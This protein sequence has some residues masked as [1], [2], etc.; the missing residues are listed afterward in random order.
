MYNYCRPL[1]NKQ[2]WSKPDGRIQEERAFSPR[3]TGV[4][5]E[6]FWDYFVMSEL[7]IEADFCIDFHVLGLPLA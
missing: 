2:E 4:V 6:F 1:G 7:E 5:P 3:I